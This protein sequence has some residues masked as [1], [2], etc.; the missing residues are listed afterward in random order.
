MRLFGK[1]SSGSATFYCFTPPVSFA[2][3]IIEFAFAFYV[4][5][6]YKATPFSRLCIVTL[7]CLGLF[8]LSEFMICKSPYIDFA[9][10]MGYISITLLPALGL[11]IIAIITR[12]W[13]PLVYLAY[14]TAVG[15]CAAAVFV[16][17]VAFIASCQP[18]YVE[19]DSNSVFSFLHSLYYGVFMFLGIFA[20][21][22]SIVK[23]IGDSKQEKWMIASYLVFIIP[24]L[25][26]SYL[27]LIAH[28]AT[29]SVMCGL[30]LITA[31]IFVFI[32]IPRYYKYEKIHK[33]IE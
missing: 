16:P 15:L 32:I 19:I 22:R 2:T 7:L 5:F 26:L 14:I 27:N 20:L 24:A 10:K 8:Q 9:L 13:K 33:S 4:F 17:N 31:L 28:L 3:F 25:V 11:H 21:W 29:A 12:R 23:R 18:H 30:A 1:R 6:R